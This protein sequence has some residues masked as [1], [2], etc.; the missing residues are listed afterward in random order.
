MKTVKTQK[1]R[2]EKVVSDDVKVAEV[3]KKVERRQGVI[4]NISNVE[5]IAH[6][7]IADRARSIWMSRGC[8]PGQ[9]EANWYQAERELM[10]EHNKE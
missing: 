6:E 3:E 2:K 8:L 5:Q 1:T 9:D 7:R 4:G 10:M